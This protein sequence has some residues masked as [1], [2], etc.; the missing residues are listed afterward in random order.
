MERIREHKVREPTMTT[1]LLP[2]ETLPRTQQRRQAVLLAQA[3]VSGRELPKREIIQ[4]VCSRALDAVPARLVAVARP[5]GAELVYDVGAGAVPS[6]A[7]RVHMD[8]SLTG[9]CFR[10]RESIM[11]ADAAQDTR[12]SLIANKAFSGRS[13]ILVPIAGVATPIGVLMA[14]SDR[15]DV[16]D[17][18]DLQAME[19]LAGIISS[20]LI[21]ASARVERQLLVAE[22]A[23][24]LSQREQSEALF[25]ALTE[26]SDEL[27]CILDKHGRIRYSSPSFTRCLGYEA[28]ELIGRLPTD[29]VHDED[30]AVMVRTFEALASGHDVSRFMLVRLRHKDGSWRYVEGNGRNLLHVPAVNGIT[31]NARDVTAR[32]EAD[33]SL[34]FQARLLQTVE[35]S[36]IAVDLAGNLTYWSAFAEKMYGWTSAEV[37]GRSVREFMVS[38]GGAAY[39]SEINAILQS[40]RSWAGEFE[41]LRKDGTSIHASVTDTPIFDGTGKVVGFVGVS[42]DVSARRALEMQLRQ[43]QKM[44]AVGQLAGGVAHDFNNILTAIIGYGELALQQAPVGAVH[45]DLLEICRAAERAGDL[46]RQLLTFSRKQLVR[47]ETVNVTQ[48]VRGMEK[49][50]RRMINESI[51]FDVLC[52]ETPLYVEAD[53]SQVEQVIMNL[54]VNARDAMPDGG[55][56]TV[57][58]TAEASAGGETGGGAIKLRVIDT[59]CGMTQ[60]VKGHIF[61]PFFTTKPEGRGTGLG[62]AVVFGVVQ[63]LGGSIDVDSTPGEGSSFTLTLPLSGAV[64][65]DPPG[66]GEGLPRGSETILLVEDSQ[67]LAVMTDRVLQSLGYRVIRANNGAAAARLP[68]DALAT[69]DLVLTDVVMPEMNGP[70]LVDDLRRRGL[71]PTVLYVSGYTHGADLASDLDLRNARFIPKPWSSRQ[72]ATEIR[73]ALDARRMAA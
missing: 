46:T 13:L 73:R 3:D 5:S 56:L 20:T 6:A 35:Q 48:V 17:D 23:E 27:I 71:S 21:A 44:E 69:V 15:P 19:Q 54:V 31:C 36:V 67:P 37:M 28:A 55:R 61:E 62:L 14:A 8:T 25:R 16:F 49:M 45:D 42:T 51:T 59:G 72:L 43:A 9:V 57:C 18:E 4:R 30:R 32:V 26:Y 53:R 47:V 41:L 66:M 50:L 68:A 70:T 24:A 33:R 60:E 58:A 34:E 7:V 2:D 52:A 29:L 39:A 1:T 11:L 65:L 63:Q 10:A 38:P 40:G 22:R 12:S 64:P